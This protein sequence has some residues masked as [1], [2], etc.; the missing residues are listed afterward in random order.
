VVL[1]LD[2]PGEAQMV[3]RHAAG[4]NSWWMPSISNDG[5]LPSWFPRAWR[6]AWGD[7]R[8]RGQREWQPSST[9]SGGQSCAF[10]AARSGVDHL[11]P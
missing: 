5:G 3:L 4:I 6:P 9:T 7:D 2:R 11:L 8:G 10:L 1:D